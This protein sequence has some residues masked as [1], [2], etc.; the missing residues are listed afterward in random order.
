MSWRLQEVESLEICTYLARASTAVARW[1][2][3]AVHA[4]QGAAHDELLLVDGIISKDHGCKR[5]RF[6]KMHR[7][8]MCE[9]LLRVFFRFV[10]G[11]TRARFNGPK[12][13]TTRQVVS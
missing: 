3:S 4:A 6:D 13:G 2:D 8:K 10:F 5:G 1:V 9:V 11:R 12:G 7:L